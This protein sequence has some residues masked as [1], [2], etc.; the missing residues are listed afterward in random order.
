MPDGVRINIPG[1]IRM[2]CPELLFNPKL[3]C[4]DCKSLQNL[5]YDSVKASDV[6]LRKELCENLM[7][8]GG[9][10]MLEGLADRLKKEINELAPAGQ[11][12]RVI[13]SADCK[14]AVWKGASIL[15]SLSTFK[16]SWITAEDYQEYGSSIVH[17]K[18]S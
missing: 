7:L 17:R 5:L 11:E 18:C 12:I 13:A 4:K 10:T 15:A 16:D 8:N 6:D 9:T 1:C 14:N 2:K 3:N